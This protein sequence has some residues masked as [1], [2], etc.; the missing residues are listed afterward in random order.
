V[1]T[2]PVAPDRD[3]GL[4][5]TY[6]G[7]VTRFG[8]FVIDIVTIAVLFVLAGHVIDYLVS[9]LRG[10]GFSITDA[11]IASDLLLAGWF[12]FYCAYPLA[13][14]GRTFGMAVVGLR[15]VRHD[16]RDLGP[17]HAIIRV[18]VFPLSFALFGFGFLLILLTRDR[19]ALHDFIANSAVVYSWNARAARLRFLGRVPAPSPD[20][21]AR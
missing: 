6:A 2:A 11:P 19:R 14:S 17:K 5:G 9:A 10:P 4:Q 18:L 20:E 21:V 12:F 8:G 13:V 15:A 7:I 1:S 3:V 16:G